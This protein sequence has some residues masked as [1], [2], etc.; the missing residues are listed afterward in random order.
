[1]AGEGKWVKLKLVNNW[2]H[3][4]Y[5]L[6]GKPVD[7]SKVG[8]LR[9]RWPDGSETEELLDQESYSA[10]VDDMGHSYHVN[11]RI[12]VASTSHRGVEHLIRLHQF[13]AVWI[14]DI[15]MSEE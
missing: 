15:L 13:K 6:R 2:E 4:S 12:P 5:E 1:M 8:T 11:G 9:V 14:P 10:H 3:L 7:L